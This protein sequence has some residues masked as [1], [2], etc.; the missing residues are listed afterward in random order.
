APRTAGR[1][2]VMA[3]RTDPTTA[4]TTATTIPARAITSTTATDRLIAGA[5]ATATTGKRAGLR[6]AIATTG[7]NT[8]ASGVRTGG[9]GDG[10]GARMPASGG[11]S[12]ARIV[13]NGGR[14]GA[15][16]AATDGAAAASFGLLAG[17]SL[18][19]PDHLVDD[20]A[21]ELFAEFGVEIRVH[22]QCAQAFDLPRL[23]SGIARREPGLGLVLAH[24]LRDAEPLRQH[25][26]EG[27]VDVVDRLAVARQDGVL[28]L[29][30]G[31]A[32]HRAQ[33]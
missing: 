29:R 2:S 24:G 3:T 12:G 23:A 6:E 18:V 1:R 32:G 27:G 25:V 22:G 31:L 26:N 15:M 9:N 5:I 21:D 10:T 33:G 4:G 17:R 7:A 20:E 16:I 19:M 13:A 8:A 28:L 14:T 11:A 30:V